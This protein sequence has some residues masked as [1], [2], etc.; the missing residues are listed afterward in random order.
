MN[1]TL[2]EAV[3]TAFPLLAM[4]P[5]GTLQAPTAAGTRYLASRNGLCRETWLPWIRVCELVAPSALVLPYGEV[6]DAVE[7][8]CGPIPNQLLHQALVHA[9]HAL[10][11][12]TAGAFLWSAATD[13]WRYAMRRALSASGEHVA[14]EEVRPQ[15]GE[16][17]VVDVHSHGGHSAYFSEQDDLDDAGAMKV[18]LV[19]GNVDCLRPSSRMRL[20]MAGVVR[21]AYLRNDGR[22]AV[23]P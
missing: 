15:P 22:L 17:L 23:L 11:L 1:H 14:Y 18:S 7:F 8:R 3:G 21:T 9:R 12:E 20:C 5:T 10:P 13:G 6:P 19:L 2:N 4:P 16:H